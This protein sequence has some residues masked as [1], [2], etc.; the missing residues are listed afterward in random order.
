MTTLGDCCL[1]RHQ[2]A[3]ALRVPVQCIDVWVW[4]GW[5]ECRTTAHG[6]RITLASLGEQWARVVEGRPAERQSSRC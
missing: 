3:Q 1:T 6:L 2:A 4:A 5:L